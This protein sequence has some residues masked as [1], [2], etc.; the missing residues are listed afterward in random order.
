[1]QTGF[2][3]EGWSLLHSVSAGMVRRWVAGTSEDSLMPELVVSVGWCRGV[4][5]VLFKMS[6]SK[7]SLHLAELGL[8]RIMMAKL[9]TEHPE[10]DIA[11]GGSCVT[12]SNVALQVTQWGHFGHNDKLTQVHRKETY[13]PH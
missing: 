10:R 4:A 12:A 3:G 11:L 8:P 1:M 5:S 6:P 2:G 7:C 13:R 9:K